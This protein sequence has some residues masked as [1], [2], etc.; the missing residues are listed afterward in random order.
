MWGKGRFAESV[1][2]GACP[3]RGWKTGP[4]AAV[5]IEIQDICVCLH[6]KEAQVSGSSDG[7]VQINIKMEQTIEMLFKSKRGQ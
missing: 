6:V 1:M 4:L 3:V 5:L 2:Y 7:D